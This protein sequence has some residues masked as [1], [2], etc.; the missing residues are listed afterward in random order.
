MKERA[1][2]K[3][4]IVLDGDFND[5]FERMLRESRKERAVEARKRPKKQSLLTFKKVF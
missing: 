3:E 2:T 1:N 4:K 5:R